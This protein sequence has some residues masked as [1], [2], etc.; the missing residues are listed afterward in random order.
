MKAI[1]S[2]L[3]QPT[4]DGIKFASK[5]LQDGK[6]VAFPTETV[7][8]L[9]A[10]ALNDDAVR[11]IF[12]AKGRPLNDPVIIHVLNKESA[13]NLI[14]IEQKNQHLFEILADNC[15]PGPLT[16]ICKAKNIV[17]STVTA[18]TGFVSV[19]CPSHPLALELLKVSGLCIAAPSANRFGHVSPTLAEHVIADL[20]EKDIHVLNGD[21]E[22]YSIYTCLHGI[23]STVLKIDEIQSKILILRQGAV[24]QHRIEQILRENRI[25]WIVEA[26][27]RTVKMETANEINETTDEPIGQEAPGQAITHYAPDV[28]C[29]IVKL[30]TDIL[31]STILSNL[32]YNVILDFNGKLISLQS[33][34]LAYRDLS[35]DGSYAEA[36]KNLF[37]ALRWAELI[38]GAVRVLLPSVLKENENNIDDVRLGLADR[39][40]RASSGI[41]LELNIS[42]EKS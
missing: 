31:I 16:I 30:T 12:T 17:P 40:F 28:P 29:V 35:V 10:N 4:I 9:G 23:E 36:A 42:N 3:I 25:N 11:S 2:L 19:R 18:G 24:T 5:L 39:I 33:H 34:A 1:K 26:I 37:E 14:E 6:L 27:Q 41:E 21:T 8:G 13:M 38:D 15:W 7:Y 20:G 22:N 32:K